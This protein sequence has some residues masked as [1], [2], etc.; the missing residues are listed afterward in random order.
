MASEWKRILKAAREQ[1]WREEE[2]K[3]GL[4]LY[5]PDKTKSPVMVHKTPSDHRALANT[6]AEMKRQGF[7]WPWFSKGR[8]ES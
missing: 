5:P 6:L 1:G 2:K 3:K 7:M 4:M 8:K